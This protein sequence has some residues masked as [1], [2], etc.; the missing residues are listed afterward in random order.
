M[1]QVAVGAERSHGCSGM[2]QVAVASRP[3]PCSRPGPQPLEPVG[4][5]ADADDGAVR[6][7][8]GTWL[9]ARV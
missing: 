5:M 8:A 3:C 1:G 7:E 2:G 4:H 9:M 6:A